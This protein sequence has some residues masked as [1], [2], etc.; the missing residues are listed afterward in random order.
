MKF[1][2]KI[3]TVTAIVALTGCGSSVPKCSDD[4]TMDV[5]RTIVEEQMDKPRSALGDLINA[6]LIK[7]NFS[8]DLIVNRGYDSDT[9]IRSCSG[10]LNFTIINTET[11]QT[12]ELTLPI[13][14]EIAPTDDGDN[15]I[16][17]IWGLD[18][19]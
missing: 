3:L 12:G 9:Q 8:F 15:F 13:T 11:K 10:N 2:L 5:A 6:G 16:V 19:L 14:Y 18:K 4:D 7:Y 1:S 17:Q